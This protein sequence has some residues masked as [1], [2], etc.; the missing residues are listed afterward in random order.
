MGLKKIKNEK[1]K[2]QEIG[3]KNI[4]EIGAAAI[5]TMIGDI[6]RGGIDIIDREDIDRRHMSHHLGVAAKAKV[7]N[8]PKN[9]EADQDQIKLIES[10]NGHKTIQKQQKNYN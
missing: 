8:R 3:E 9:K 10:N 6:D 5:L 4:S 2:N 1:E 7:R